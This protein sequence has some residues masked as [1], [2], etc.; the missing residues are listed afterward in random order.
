MQHVFQISPSKLE[1]K[2]LISLSLLLP[3][4]N[5]FLLNHPLVII[6]Q[7][8]IITFIYITKH[9][10]PLSKAIYLQ[11]LSENWCMVYE[12]GLAIQFKLGKFCQNRKY[13]VRLS[14]KV[15]QH[16]QPKQMNYFDWLQLQFWLRF[17]YGLTLCFDSLDLLGWHGLKIWLWVS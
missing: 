12:N 17:G 8:L 3:I 9:R 16:N 13:W 5:V 10:T 11:R 14:G 6:W 1:K 2:I 4:E 15:I 7:W